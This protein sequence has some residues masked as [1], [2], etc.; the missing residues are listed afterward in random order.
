[1]SD[2]ITRWFP[3][4]VKPVRSGLYQVLTDYGI[5]WCWW[6]GAWGWAY[7]NKRWALAREWRKSEGATQSKTWRG[8]AAPS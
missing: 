2:E 8:L 6:D 1:M 3:D 5:E 7:P 4:R